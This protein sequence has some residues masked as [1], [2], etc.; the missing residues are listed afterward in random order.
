MLL[1]VSCEVTQACGQLGNVLALEVVGGRVVKLT[2]GIAAL[3]CV[4]QHVRLSVLLDGAERVDIVPEDVGCDV[5]DPV[6][7]DGFP[8]FKLGPWY[9]CR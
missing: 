6:C 3:C 8:P 4:V 2:D 1:N 9:H 7:V 5:V